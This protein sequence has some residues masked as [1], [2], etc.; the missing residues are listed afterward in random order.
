MSSYAIK[1]SISGY[2]EVW[3]A[4]KQILSLRIVQGQD[5]KSSNCS[6]SLADPDGTIAN[7]LIDHSLNNGGLQRLPDDKA[8]TSGNSTPIA[9]GGSGVADTTMTPNRKAFLDMLAYA[10]GTY[11]E[12]DGGYLT[13]VGYSYFT[14]TADHP[15]QFVASM[16]SD[17]AGRYQFLST[18]WDGLGLPDFSPANQDKGGI[19]LVDGRGALGMVDSGQ[20]EAAIFA[21]NQEWASLPG[22]PHGQPRKE[23]GELLRFYNQRLAA[24]Q[25]GSSVTPTAPTTAEA[26]PTATGGT[27]VKGGS[28]TI[29]VGSFSWD[30]LHTRTESSSDGVTTLTGQ[31]VRAALNKRQ[32]TRS[33]AELTLKDLATRITEAAG[34]TLDWQADFNPTYA[35]VHSY[36]LTDYALL[37][38][39]CQQCGLF[40]S[41]EEGKLTI[42]SLDQLA[43]TD[44]VL[45]PGLNLI[46]WETRDEWLDPSKGGDGSS[47]LPSEA[48][49]T[50]DPIAGTVQKTPA[51]A[52]TPGK[53]KALTGQPSEKPTAALKDGDKDKA[54]Q[55]RSRVKRLKGL[56]SVFT[57]PLDDIS[58]TYKPLKAVRTQGLPGVLSRIWVID[59]VTHDFTAGTT[60]LGC[61]SPVDVPVT[62]TE[63][64]DPS[65]GA[66]TGGTVTWGYPVS[67]FPVTDVRRWR[68]S[69]RFHHGIDVGTPTGTPCYAM[70]DGVVVFG[71]FASGYGLVLYI[72]T[73]DSYQYRLAHLDSLVARTGQQVKKGELVAYTGNTGI[74]TGE[75]LHLEIRLPPGETGES[76][77]LSAVGLKD[78]QVGETFGT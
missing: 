62:E 38:R 63:S 17:A 13:I 78:Y 47:Q 20:I 70:A 24:Y 61:Y 74:G 40:I 15:R 4:G 34:V 30:F 53:D 50:I 27:Q 32:Y 46:R 54:A 10:E 75:H 12:P 1:A 2:G 66:P 60:T 69:S 3:E 41:D 48:K 37:V 22:S 52:V 68:S 58:L 31:S 76:A 64:G 51:P 18:T 11:S 43:D 39:E 21:C 35:Y 28:I 45:K 42:K 72:N 55:A 56:P 14:S 9:P 6:L 16:N 77:E 44:A 25:G 71:A 19:M 33:E 65:P 26:Q 57:V 59:I 7:R 5:D 23:M 29:A 8:P 67:G 73:A 36:G 49:A